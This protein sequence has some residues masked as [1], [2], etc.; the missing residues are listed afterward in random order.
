MLW[1]KTLNLASSKNT[2]INLSYTFVL[3][4]FNFPK[5]YWINQRESREKVQC[6]QFK[7]I[8]LHVSMLYFYYL[9]R[10]TCFVTLS[11]RSV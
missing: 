10:V 9:R 5:R 7:A 4:I 2:V 1:K 8:T 11:Y 6:I 3:N